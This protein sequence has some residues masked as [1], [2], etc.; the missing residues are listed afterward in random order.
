MELTAPFSSATDLLKSATDRSTWPMLDWTAE[1]EEVRL[2]QFAI[3]DPF[4][5]SIFDFILAIDFVMLVIFS[6]NLDMLFSIE[7]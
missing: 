5:D 7:E 4:S 1:I 6:I 3:T 2:L